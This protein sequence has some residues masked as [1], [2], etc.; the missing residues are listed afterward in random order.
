LRT[1]AYR[2]QTVPHHSGYIRF[3]SFTCVTC[4]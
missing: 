3:P 2:R 4:A 1:D